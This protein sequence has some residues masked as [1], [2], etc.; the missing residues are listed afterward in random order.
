MAALFRAR[1]AAGARPCLGGELA[2][3]E[4][5]TVGMLRDIRSH[6]FL[7][8]VPLGI[9]LGKHRSDTLVQL[10]ITVGRSLVLSLSANTSEVQ[11]LHHRDR[12][13]GNVGGGLTFRSSFPSNLFVTLPNI[14]P[15]LLNCCCFCF[16]NIASLAC[17]SIR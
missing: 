12:D 7:H 17:D 3:I 16:A 9:T 15:V 13:S 14:P 8:L 5:S 2:L 10:D 11:V 1:I 4:L 6:G